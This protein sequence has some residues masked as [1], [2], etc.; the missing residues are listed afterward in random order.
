M[1]LLVRHLLCFDQSNVLE[2]VDI[3]I[4]TYQ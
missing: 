1:E 3:A 4:L 2:F